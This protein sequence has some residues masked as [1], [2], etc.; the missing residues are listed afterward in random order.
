[1]RGINRQQIFEDDAD[2]TEFLSALAKAK[3]QSRFT[4]YAYCLMGNHV[5]L[6]LK[7]GTEP[8]SHTF[9][10]LGS[11]YVYRY[12][13]KYQR[14]GH[15]FQDR[16]KSEAVETTAYFIAVL[17]YIYQNPV[18]AGLCE[19]AAD[20]PWSSYGQPGRPKTIV[21][22]AELSSIVPR[23][24]LDGLAD[25][26]SEVSPFTD[27]RRGR[28][29]RYLDSEVMTL[30]DE[31]CGAKTLARFQALDHGDQMLVT[32]QLLERHVSVRQVA[33]VL[34]LSRGVVERCA[35]EAGG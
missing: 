29:T 27:G 25:A 17:R 13:Q 9:K 20:Y 26:P 21:D 18:R 31:F 6:L 10:R 22:E 1:L 5:H 35:R 19:R 23:E 15:L 28:R 8:L 7:E 12:N 11:R 30:V 16:F 3:E 2:R 32:R 4:L 24:D 34:G 33:R 14:C